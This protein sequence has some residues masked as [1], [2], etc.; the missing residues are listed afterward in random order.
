MKLTNSQLAFLAAIILTAIL[1]AAFSG[2]GRADG[3][4]APSKGSFHA[5]LQYCEDCHGPSGQGYLG[6]LPIPRLAGQTS[7]YIQNQLRA[8]VERRR[9]NNVAI[10]MSRVHGLPPELQTA[11]ATQFSEFNPKPFGRAPRAH[12][13]IGQKI[14]GEGLPDANVPACAACHGPEA[15]GIGPVPRLAGQLYP[16]LVKELTNW[17]TERGQNPG[18]ADT[19][20][21]MRPIAQS[22]TKSQIEAVA[23]YLSDLE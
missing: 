21:I 14:Y 2:P 7:E 5:K 1:G 16:Y 8:F 18:A 6:Y 9:E 3:T 23:A 4:R 22:L 19:S 12:A 20:A 15:K 10:V 11:L 13:D 17:G